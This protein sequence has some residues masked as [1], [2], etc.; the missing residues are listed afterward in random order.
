MYY[1]NNVSYVLV[2]IPLKIPKP[3]LQWNKCY[4]TLIHCN[5]LCD[6]NFSNVDH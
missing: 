1:S 3:V 6:F 4:K 5:I 2:I